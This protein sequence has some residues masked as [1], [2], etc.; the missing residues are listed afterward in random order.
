MNGA[1]GTPLTFDGGGPGETMTLR[2]A[3]PDVARNVRFIY[4]T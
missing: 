1:S 2:M 3:T 4:G